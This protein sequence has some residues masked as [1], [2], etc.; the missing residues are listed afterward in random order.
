MNIKPLV[1]ALIESY[2][3]TGETI[4]VSSTNQL[5]RSVIIETVEKLRCILFPS[6]FGKKNIEAE[7]IEYYTGNLLE[8]IC[9]NFTRQI[10]QALKHRPDCTAACPEKLFSEAE[11]ICT[12]FLSQ[13][14]SIRSCLATDIEATFD[15]DPAAVSKDEIISSY[16]GIFAITVYRLAHVL[17][18]LDVPL[19]PRIMTEHAHNITGIDIHPGAEIGHHFFIDHGTGIVI[20]GT[21]VIGNYVKIYQGVTLGGLSTR[22]GQALRGR[23]RH[24]TVADHVTIYSGASILGGATHIGTDVVIGGNSFVTASVPDKTKVSVKNLEL[25]FKTDD[26]WEQSESF[27]DYQI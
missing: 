4:T 12:R 5:N 13:L 9:F 22:G 1:D 20:G 6:H 24:P 17:M 16:P 25:R 10:A 26:T 7:T 27:W 23:K 11:I 14:P 8:D 2:K 15:G 3:E 18:L 19:I 21:T